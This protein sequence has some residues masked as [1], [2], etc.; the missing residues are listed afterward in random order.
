MVAEITVEPEVR[1]V[2]SGGGTIDRKTEHLKEIIFLTKMASPTE[3]A[4]LMEARLPAE[5]EPPVISP[6]PKKPGGR[7]PEIITA[8][9]G[10][11]FQKGAGKIPAEGRRLFSIDPNGSP[12]K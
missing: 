11:A 5:T 7:I 1:N 10:T 12:Q 2:R 3:A 4:L 8:R 9:T 6:G